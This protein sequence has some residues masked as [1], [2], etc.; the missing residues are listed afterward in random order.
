[1]TCKFV[2]CL[3]DNA[4]FNDNDNGD[5]CQYDD[6]KMTISTVRLYVCIAAIS[7]AVIKKKR[8]LEK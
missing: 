2:D 3:Y 6:S 7:E 4:Y 5:I 1:M 8:V